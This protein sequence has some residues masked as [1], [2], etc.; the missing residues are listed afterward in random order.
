[1]KKLISLLCVSML[2]IGMIT[3][4]AVSASAEED[5]VEK[6]FTAVDVKK[7][8]EV[9]YI[10]KLDKVAQ[11][12]IGSDFSVYYDSSV[13]DLVSV[14]DYDDETDPDEWTAVINTE[15]DGEVR[16]VWSILKGVKFSSKRNLITVNLKA[17]SDADESHISYRVRFLYDNDVFNS[18]DNPQITV[19]KF[20][21][22]VSLNG[23][24]VLE[25]AP[26]EWNDTEAEE[27]GKFVGSYD[28]DS[29]NAGKGIKGVV[30]QAKD[31]TGNGKSQGVV[32]G[33]NAADGSG[34]GSGGS[35][36]G[37][38]GSGNG[39]GG[40]GNGSG[41]SGNGS[42]GSGNGSSGGSGGV[43]GG[44]PAG[45]SVNN[46]PLATTAE[47]YYILATDADGNV[48]ATSD[49]APADAS[50][51]TATS[52]GGSSPVLWII[53]ALVVLA[54]GGVAVYFFMKK[55]S[56]A[57][58]AAPADAAGAAGAV[59]AAGAADGAPASDVQNISD[60]A[61]APNTD[62]AEGEEKTEILDDTAE[63]TEVLDDS[64]KTVVLDEENKTQI[65]DDPTESDET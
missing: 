46:A 51:N 47:G 20:T 44:Q 25:D 11:P 15:L 23:D 18:A 5:G 36:N 13:F 19:Y 56:G 24:Q 58:T 6:A 32:S 35:G 37:S 38:G 59:D 45:S 8:D 61:E 48:I 60:A 21:C 7:G 65:A 10:L 33:D 43:S 40:S 2:I 34:N 28:G 30:D 16:G 1:M 49:E 54:G 17:K 62:A 57:K 64:E 26:P 31:N 52:K 4:S 50:M 12:I 22:D 39:S 53:I 29:E 42:G 55:S 27:N 63:K 41:G 3:V 9:K 14:A